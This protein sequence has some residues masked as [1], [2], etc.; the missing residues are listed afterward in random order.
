MIARTSFCGLL[1]AVMAT[2][3]AVPAI[4]AD[5]SRLELD[6]TAIGFT[7]PQNTYGPW[8]FQNLHYVYV[9]PGEGALNV[10]F[11][12]QT[13][14]DTGNFQNGY[15]IALGLVRD[16][17]PYLYGVVDFGAGTANPYAKSLLHTELAYK[18]P[19]D[20]RWQIDGS[21]DFIGYQSGQSLRQT[22]VGPNYISRTFAVQMRYL[23]QVN[24]GA[25]T[26]SGAYAALDVMPTRRS[27]YTVT[28][29]W[30]P[31]QYLTQVGALP[32][33]LANLDGQ[34][35]TLGTEQ[36]IGPTNSLGQRLGVRVLGFYSHLNRVG[37]SPLYIG[38]G[39]TLGFW[40]QF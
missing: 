16:F 37:G 9:I 2:L 39:V 28:G 21:E 34:T 7:S 17:T 33:T 29:L 11:S 19:A 3:G 5:S 40:S 13:D 36:Q 14:K 15:Y 31:Q 38:R 27:K 4:A 8:Q 10:E 20:W 24:S 18:I 12:H 25:T 30:G 35:Y 6:A 22:M 1:V 32:L 26:Q 23:V